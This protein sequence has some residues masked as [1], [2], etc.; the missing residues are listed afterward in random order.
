MKHLLFID[1]QWQESKTTAKILS[2]FTGDTAAESC[3]ADDSQIE[4]A[5]AACVNA[6]HPFSKTSRFLRSKLLMAIA[7]GLQ[8]SR[9][10]IVN[11]MIQE[12]G[13]P[14]LLSDTE[15]TRAIQTFTWAAEEVKR[16]GGEVVP[17]DVDAGGRPFSEATCLFKPRGPILG[18]TPFNFPLNLV[19]HKVAPALAVGCPI[20]IKSAPQAPGGAAL[21]AKIFEKAAKSVNAEHG[22]GREAI[23]MAALQVLACSNPQAEILVKDPRLPTVSFTGSPGVGFRIQGSA[24][25]K[26]VILELGGNAGVIVHEDADL[27]RAAARCAF[28]GMS[29]AGQT[30]ISVQRIFVHEKVAAEFEKLLTAE[31]GKVKHGDPSQK[32]VIVGPVIDSKAAER[33]EAWIQEAKQDPRTKV[34]AGGTRNKNV[35][36]PTLLLNPPS[37]SKISCEEVFGPVITLSTYKTFQEA[38]VQVN[39]SKFG[40]QA[41]V[42]TRDS[43]RIHQA[44]ENLEVGGVLVNEVPTF[45]ADHMP[46]GGVKQSGLGR[47]GLK[48][49]MEEFCE[50]RI[51]V[52]YR[53]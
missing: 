21:L 41:G 29:Y 24:I 33:I 51:L 39:D 40:L 36:A 47:E 50:R 32:D 42:F 13:K 10:E 16:F 46:Y 6:T 30:C 3:Q 34:L 15:V 48:Y 5:I 43:D 12:A 20:L 8:E 11:S 2:P 7:Q 45:R 23:P 31:V 25:G 44:F 18:I 27:S 37:Q 19:A 9:A 4:K 52:Q 26:K 53:G 49:A 22:A 1:G 17:M 14:W 38:I 35:V 28:G